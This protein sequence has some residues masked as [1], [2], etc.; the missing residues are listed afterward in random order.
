M[1]PFVSPT[2]RLLFVGSGTAAR[3][4]THALAAFSG[5]ILD[6]C[7]DVVDATIVRFHLYYA[8]KAMSMGKFVAKLQLSLK[9]VDRNQLLS[10]QLAGMYIYV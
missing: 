7:I 6:E 8:C 10:N 3:C 2:R 1:L 9:N 5:T 4:R